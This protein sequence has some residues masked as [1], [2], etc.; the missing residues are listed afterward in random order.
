MAPEILKNIP[1]DESADMWSVGVII[2][3]ILCGHPPFADEVQAKLFEK[4]RLGDYDMESSGWK[5]ISEDAKHLIRNLLQINPQQRWTAKQ[6]LHCKWLVEDDPNLEKVILEETLISIKKR[7]SRLKNVAKT[8]MWM[9]RHSIGL[10]DSDV[11]AA[12]AAAAAAAAEDESEGG[13]DSVQRTS[14]EDPT[15]SLTENDFSEMSLAE[16]MAGAS[17]KAAMI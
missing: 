16:L 15:L 14:E 11:Q 8:I 9:N 7:K 4:I 5:G 6:A 1:Y 17:D 2:Y 3:V 10:A 13:D 12:A